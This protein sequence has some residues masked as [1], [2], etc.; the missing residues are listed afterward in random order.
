MRNFFRLISFCFSLFLLLLLLMRGLGQSA[1]A[2]GVIAFTQV[3]EAHDPR[4]LLLD[5]PSG[6]S[7]EITSDIAEGD[8]LGRQPLWSP[9]GNRLA[10]WT[11]HNRRGSFAYEVQFSDYT[12]SNLTELWH[13]FS[14]PIYG[15]Q[16]ERAFANNP[17]FANSPLYLV[18]ETQ[19]EGSVLRESIIAPQFSPDG[20]YLAYLAFYNPETKNTLSAEETEVGR[21]ETD[22]YIFNRQT[23]E[24]RNWTLDINTSGLPIWSADSRYIAFTSRQRRLGLIY[25][26]DLA[27]DT[28]E[29]IAAQTAAVSPPQWSANGRYLAFVT[30]QWGNLE[31]AILDMQ[32]KS[33]RNVSNHP[34]YD[35]QPTWS[36]DSHRLAFISR[37]DGQDEIY[38][39]DIATN[40]L[41]RLSHSQ[42]NETDPAWRPR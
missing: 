16:G 18:E 20:N 25:L 14:L 26:L 40:E 21:F 41:Q 33:I 6:N 28:I 30:G 42:E 23:G 2:Q 4:V 9:D 38:A 5:V 17:S 36:P 1:S 13:Y 7:L 19:S 37:R 24:E 27:N 10:F 32:D 8:V 3:D 35:V 31:I 39:Y 34:L 22:L 11:Y 15:A 29:P 12:I